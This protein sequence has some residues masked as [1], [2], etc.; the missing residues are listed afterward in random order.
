MTCKRIGFQYLL[1]NAL[2][3]IVTALT[4]VY[5][6]FGGFEGINLHRQVFI[7]IRRGLSRCA[8]FIHAQN[9]CQHAIEIID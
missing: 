3:S 9:F 5:V 4:L 8:V 7:V 6:R 1:S 2:P